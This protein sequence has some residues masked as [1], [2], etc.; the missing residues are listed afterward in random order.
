MMTACVIGGVCFSTIK[1]EETASPPINDARPDQIKIT[2][3]VWPK[4]IQEYDCYY[5]VFSV[6][7]LSTE[8]IRVNA[9]DWFDTSKYKDPKPLGIP[10]ANFSISRY[11]HSGRGY[12]GSTGGTGFMRYKGNRVVLGNTVV[13]PGETRAILSDRYEATPGGEL[14]Q[15]LK[16]KKSVNYSVD[17]TNLGEKYL[18]C[19]QQPFPE[20]K[21]TMRPDE[22]RRFLDRFFSLS[23]DNFGQ[24]QVTT[25]KGVFGPAAFSPLIFAFGYQRNPDRELS[26][27]ADWVAIEEKFQPGTLCDEIRLGRLQVQWLDG[28]DE[29]ALN[30]LREWFAEMEPIQSMTL[31]A[32]LCLPEGQAEEWEN[33]P[34][35]DEGF[36]YMPTFFVPKEEV[37]AHRES[38]RKAFIE[39]QKHYREMRLAIDDV[40]RPYNTLPKRKLLEKSEFE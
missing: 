10:I 2:L 25:K 19:F 13:F 1:A 29:A 17:I 39:S 18:S 9:H 31:A 8:P 38:S 37:E 5:V 27:L 7:N 21:V 12:L 20:F 30:E 3:D 4:E 34:V 32:S 14:P 24:S 6:E 15:I 35:S 28:Q 26:T 16:E 36:V 23:N 33:V 40:V 22:E 11:E